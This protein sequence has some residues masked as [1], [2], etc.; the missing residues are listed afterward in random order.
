MDPDR[1]LVARVRAGDPH[2]FQQLV[3][4]HR[5][6]LVRYASSRLGP[7]RPE[8]EDVVQD[9]MVRAYDA[10]R[11]GADPPNPTAWLFTIV[12]NRAADLARTGRRRATRELDDA[13]VSPH[14]EVGVELDRREQV[15]VALTAIGELP[16]RQREALVGVA[17]GGV[18]YEELASAQ[19]TSVSAVKALVNRARTSVRRAAAAA[20]LLPPACGQRLRGWALVARDHVDGVAG[21]AL[22]KAGTVAA[23]G[24]IGVGVAPHVPLPAVHSA[25]PPAAAAQAALAHAQRTVSA[26]GVAA[27]PR[28]AGT[29]TGACSTDQAEYGSCAAQRTTQASCAARATRRRTTTAP[30][31]SSTVRVPAPSD[32]V[33]TRPPAHCTL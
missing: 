6:A 33:S 26:A 16:E 13:I 27:A 7:Y 19:D 9:A 17:L 10:L 29:G 20:A 2:A 25:A 23:V 18:S 24:A 28:P 31:A 11:R 1:G 14:D 3:A 8:A 22:A 5:P 32:G 21:G 4:R 30:A 12:R 15:R